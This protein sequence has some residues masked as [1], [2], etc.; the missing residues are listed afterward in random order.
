[1]IG[2]FVQ[3]RPLY[4]IWVISLVLISITI[5]RILIKENIRRREVFNHADDDVS[6]ARVDNLVNFD[7]VKYFANEEF[8]QQRFAGL[9][10]RW[11]STLQAYFF[12]F[13]YFD[14]I[15]GNIVNVALVGMMMLALFDL[16]RTIISL[17]Q[18]LLVTTFTMTLFPKM[19]NV[20]I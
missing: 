3:L 9:L 20:Y 16:Q 7:T 11:Y 19:M 18:F 2:A 14:G 13:R 8:E 5:S 12:T 4:I 15:V 6:S 1:M 17:P 10:G